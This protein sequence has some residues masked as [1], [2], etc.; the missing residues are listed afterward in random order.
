[1]NVLLIG[2]S[3]LVIKNGLST[4]IPEVLAALGK[5][6]E[7]VYNISVGATGS[8]FGLENLTL[9]NKKDIDLVFIE[10]G[11]NDLPTFSNDKKLWET[12]YRRLI[13]TLIGK[14]PSAHIVKILLG[15]QPDRFWGKQQDMHAK[16]KKIACDQGALVVDVDAHL[17]SKS[18]IYAGVEKF[19]KDD[20]HYVSPHITQFISELVVSDYLMN[21]SMG[22]FE[23]VK[24]KGRVKNEPRL[25]IYNAPGKV[26]CFENS[27]F[28]RETTVIDVGQS[29]EIDVLGVPV[30][31][32]FISEKVSCSLLVEGPGFKKI[33]NTRRK[34][35]DGDKFSFLLKQIPLYRIPP[36]NSPENESI[37]IHLT[38][39][40]ITSDQWEEQAVQRTFG[41][42]PA[43]KNDASKVYISH[44][45]TLNN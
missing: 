5:K 30:A 13:R 27:K 11:I 24:L 32:S 22:Y 7:N 42:V 16:M 17:K 15:R 31:V 14:Y 43:D 34:E 25:N 4:K 1:M 20:S 19:Y 8:L 45:C 41:M 33:L 35:A 28:K 18:D 9:F 21:S 36:K 26:T 3:N 37:K 40:D 44:L 12:G 23:M 39:I 6:V 29:V 10:Y 2:G 38:A